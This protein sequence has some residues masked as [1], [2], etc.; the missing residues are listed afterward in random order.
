LWQEEQAEESEGDERVTRKTSQ[1]WSGVVEGF[2][3]LREGGDEMSARYDGLTSIKLMMGPRPYEGFSM[4][5]AL[6]A[7]ISS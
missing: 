1:P 3:D 6:F 5:M 2:H 7:I 4:S